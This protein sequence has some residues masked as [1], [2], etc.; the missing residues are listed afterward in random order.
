VLDDFARALRITHYSG[1]YN[2]RT[3]LGFCSGLALHLDDPWTSRLLTA[4][5]LLALAGP[6]A[7][8]GPARTWGLA[9]L[10]TLFYKPISPVPHT[11]LDQPWFLIQGVSLA[12]PVAWAL[13]AP[14]LVA[15]L[16]L[17]AVAA[18]LYAA[19]PRRA[20]KYCDLTASARALRGLVLGQDPS[21]PP[22][23]GC[24]HFFGMFAPFPWEDYRDLLA[25]LRTS[26]APETRVANVLRA[27]PL[28]TINGPAGRA[29]PFPAAGGVIH[30]WNVD[31]GLKSA[32]VASLERA[33]DDTVVVWIP[34]EPRVPSDLRLPELERAIREHYRPETRFGTIEVW[35]RKPRAPARPAAGTPRFAF[36]PSAARARPPGRR[37]RRRPYTPGRPPSE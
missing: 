25:Y 20:P 15:P 10:G 23:P 18:V 9:L 7:L 26:T 6:A 31:A 16:R 33:P 11:Y 14:Y 37:R 1:S 2:T 34:N 22:P 36:A 8:R 17:A 24:V 35:R 5:V 12:L 4:E 30:L 28:P 29:T 3:W 19:A 21:D 27:L 32:F 13:T